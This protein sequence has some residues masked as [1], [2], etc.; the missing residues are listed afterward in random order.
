[1]GGIL[2]LLLLAARP[3]LIHSLAAVELNFPWTYL[4][5]PPSLSRLVQEMRKTRQI[6][7]SLVCV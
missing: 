3:G 5:L 6:S 1:M 7:R 4:W 2:L